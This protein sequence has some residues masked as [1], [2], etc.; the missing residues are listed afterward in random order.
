MCSTFTMLMR[1]FGPSHQS[2]YTSLQEATVSNGLVP[3]LDSPNQP[4]TDQFA[5]KY[6]DFAALGLIFGYALALP[7][8]TS[9]S[10]GPSSCLHTL[11]VP[12]S[13]DFHSW[14]QPSASVHRRQYSTG[15]PSLTQSPSGIASTPSSQAVSTSASYL[16]LPHPPPRA[17]L[18]KSQ[19]L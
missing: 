10:L 2:I 14:M 16:S 9:S 7:Q 15:F 5:M 1:S 19:L 4:T 6:T 13:S 17:P 8:A 11:S 3:C 12:A 18:P